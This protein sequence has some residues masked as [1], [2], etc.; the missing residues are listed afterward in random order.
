MN[1][2]ND[3][4]AVPSKTHYAALVFD[5]IYIPGDRRSEECPGHGYP[6]S[7][8]SVVRYITFDSVTEMENWVR[9]EEANSWKKENY[10]LIEV[11][12]L[13]VKHTINVVK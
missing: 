8:E 6:A 5:S 10:K 7:T 11:T 1:Y 12:P 9:K 2:I 13:A 3:K 4:S